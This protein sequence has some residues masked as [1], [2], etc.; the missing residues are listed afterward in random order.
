MI[1]QYYCKEK[2]DPGHSQGVKGY[3]AINSCL[4]DLTCWKYKCLGGEERMAVRGGGK[5]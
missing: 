4:M 3:G 5:M 2:L 1:Q